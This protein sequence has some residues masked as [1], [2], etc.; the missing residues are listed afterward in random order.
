LP[1]ILAKKVIDA[2]ERG[3]P[4]RKTVAR[5]YYEALSLEADAF[6]AFAERQ[7]MSGED[8]CKL[9]KPEMLRGIESIGEIIV[10]NS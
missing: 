6:C 10:R 4:D 2:Y 7:G 1:K 9:L 3:D 8:I 5:E